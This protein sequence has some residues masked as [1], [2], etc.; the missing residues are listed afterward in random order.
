MRPVISAKY[1]GTVEPH[2][3]LSCKIKLHRGNWTAGDAEMRSKSRKGALLCSWM[4]VNF[5]HSETI[6]DKR[7]EMHSLDCGAAIRCR[8]FIRR[9]RRGRQLAAIGGVNGW[10][11][12]VETV[13]GGGTPA[14]GGHY[15]LAQHT[16]I[17][18]EELEFLQMV[19]DWGGT[20]HIVEPWL[21]YGPLHRRNMEYPIL[22]YSLGI[23]VELRPPKSAEGVTPGGKGRHLASQGR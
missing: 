13:F 21:E 7:G 18:T 16:S 4:T 20:V 22:Y 9:M 14:S 23:S 5:G 3:V 12:G 8:V 17:L 11:W 2:G 15:I 6:N 10:Q 19:Q 1:A